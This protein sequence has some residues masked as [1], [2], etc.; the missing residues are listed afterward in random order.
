VFFE[1]GEEEP[2][3]VFEEEREEGPEGWRRI[4]IPDG[5]RVFFSVVLVVLV[6]DLGRVFVILS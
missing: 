5:F 3:E 2:E 1:E 6:L 4:I